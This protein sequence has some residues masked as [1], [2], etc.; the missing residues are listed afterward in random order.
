MEGHGAM[1]MSVTGG[2]FPQ[3]LFSA[4]SLTSVSHYFF[5]NVYSL[6]TDLLLGFVIAGALGAWVPNDVWSKLFISGHG[7]LTDVWGALIGPLVALLSFVCSVG[8]V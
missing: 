5:M 4:R 3:R 8:N 2:P 7:G 1:D 6:W